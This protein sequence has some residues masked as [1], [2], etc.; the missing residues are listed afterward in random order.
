MRWKLSVSVVHTTCP[1]PNDTQPTQ[2]TRTD[3]FNCTTTY[4]AEE[5]DQVSLV[6]SCKAERIHRIWIDSIVP[7]RGTSYRKHTACQAA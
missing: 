4:Y 1:L 2:G 6:S 7:E 5:G 3:P